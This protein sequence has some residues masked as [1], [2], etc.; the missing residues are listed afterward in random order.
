MMLGIVDKL[1]KL[2]GTHLLPVVLV[3]SFGLKVLNNL[4]P[5]KVSYD[6]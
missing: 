5:I 1:H 3:R 6:L 4:E 2:F